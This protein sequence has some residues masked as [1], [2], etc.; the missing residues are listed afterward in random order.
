MYLLCYDVECDGVHMK[1]TKKT[2]K[3]EKKGGE[4]LCYVMISLYV[5]CCGA[6]DPMWGL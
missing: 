6:S 3:K 1:T 2:R 5:M 4:C